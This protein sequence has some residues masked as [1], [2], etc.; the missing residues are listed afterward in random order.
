MP[1]TA[2]HSPPALN[3]R[4]F[5]SALT[6]AAA[7]PLLAA[8]TAARGAGG[9]LA[10]DAPL[11]TAVARDTRLTVS[12]HTTE[13]QLEGAGL[14]G[15]LPFTVAG[16]PN[17]SAGPDVIQ[18]F[19]ARS[20]DVASNAGVPPIQAAAI[21]FAAR[22]VAV[23]TKPVP[24]YQFGTAPGT[25]ITTLADLRGKRIAFSQGQAQ[26]VVVLRTLKEL[27]LSTKD[28]T[29]TPLT[30]NQFLT[31]LQARQVDVAPLSEPSTTKYLQQYGR[32]GARAL[33]MHAVDY[34]TVLWSPVEVLTDPAKAAAVRAFIPYWVRGQIWA[35]ENP[36]KWIDLYYV[37]DQGVSAADGQRIV[38]TTPKPVVP[39]SWE[40]AIAWEQET[41]DLLAEGGFVPRVTASE[42]FDRRFERVAAEA[43][44]PQYR[45]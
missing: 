13:K 34:L 44:T 10:A 33:D 26:G 27:G 41:A 18:A 37:K 31:A 7:L 3:R 24:I 2:P 15:D 14:L 23:V 43:A 4:A 35:Y 22:I 16:W 42:L 45:E 28:V 39:A 32:D 40:R 11:P 29:L 17:I 5:L 38:A 36:E 1:T 6:G 19:R 20:V 9:G 12:I 8:C 21:G 30:S 25:A